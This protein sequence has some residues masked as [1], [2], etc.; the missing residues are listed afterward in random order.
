MYQVKSAENQGWFGGGG[1]DGSK[2]KVA[3]NVL[4]T[5]WFWNFRNTMKF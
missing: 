5:F 3:Q 1:G 4:N 2:K